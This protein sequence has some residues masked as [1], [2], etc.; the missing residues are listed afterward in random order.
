LTTLILLVE[1]EHMARSAV[2][3]ISKFL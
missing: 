3:V 1:I 2:I